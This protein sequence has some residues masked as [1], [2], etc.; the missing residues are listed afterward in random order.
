MHNLRFSTHALKLL[1]E[2][3][4]S[5]ERFPS[6]GH[7]AMYA[8]LLP[9][10]VLEKIPEWL[11]AESFE[12][13]YSGKA[14]APALEEFTKRV[15][16]WSA[17][18]KIRTVQVEVYSEQ[19]GLSFVSHVL[20][21]DAQSVGR[22]SAVHRARRRFARKVGAECSRNLGISEKFQVR[23]S[24]NILA[25][26][27][28]GRA[29][30]G[31]DAPEGGSGSEEEC[32]NVGSANTSSNSK[33]NSKG[34][35]NTSSNSK[36]NTNSKGKDGGKNKES[37]PP[38]NQQTLLSFAVKNTAESKPR[39]LTRTRTVLPGRMQRSV[40]T[41]RVSSD[42]K[43]PVRMVFFKL[44]GQIR[45]PCY[46]ARESRQRVRVRNSLR[47][48]FTDEEYLYNSEDEWVEG[49]G[50]D[51]TDES[52][53]SYEEEEEAQ[54]WIEEDTEEGLI[55]KGQLPKLDHPVCVEYPVN[56]AE[57]LGE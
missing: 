52:S 35:G 15:E 18:A 47:K 5:K 36:G 10:P 25:Q 29:S 2:F 17:C 42:V 6:D 51:I 53:E 39:A 9:V 23:L 48:I 20:A 26:S 31:E 16:E 55:R 21:V 11:S 8:D 41:F 45:P 7:L 28:D 27:G 14:G 12:Y 3:K 56:E 19:T 46:Q 44:H 4:R 54:E 22:G 13:F 34:K 57:A 24:E 43:K 33:G 30:M 40:G 32:E 50:E 37:K 49:D 1:L 38:A